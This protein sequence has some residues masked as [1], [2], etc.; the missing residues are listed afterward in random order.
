MPLSHLYPLDE[1]A[2]CLCATCNNAKSDIFPVDFYT[3]EKLISLSK[4][5][6]L[7][8]ELLKSR[9]ANQKVINLLKNKIIWFVDDFLNHPEY[10]KIRDGKKA[11]DSILNSVNKAISKSDTKFDILEEYTKLKD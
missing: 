7:P 10:V 1:S 11:A 4:L 5:T 8:I 3:G 6:G 9:K 2:T